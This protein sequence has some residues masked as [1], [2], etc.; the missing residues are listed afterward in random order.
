MSK[1]SFNPDVDVVEWSGTQRPYDIIK[2]G[3]IALVVMSLLVVLLSVLFSSPDDRPA[4]LRQWSHSDPVDFATTAFSEL[5][6]SSGTAGYGQPY[7]NTPNATQTIGPLALQRWMGVRIPVHPAADFVLAPLAT[8]PDNPAIVAALQQWKLSS[9]SE[10]TMWM[11]NYGKVTPSFSNG[12][13]HLPDVNAGPIPVLMSS[14]TAMARAGSLDQSLLGGGRNYY[15][16]DYTRP[17]L[18]LADGNWFSGLAEKQHL[19][20]DQWGMMNETG[21]Y[22]G[23]AWLWLYTFWYQVPPFNASANADSLIWGLMM[24]LTVIMIFV[25]FIPGV[26]SIPRRTKVYRLIWRNH[27]RK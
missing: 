15:S 5:N 14:L 10:R 6:G 26:R 20:G 21:S 3:T 25:P 24:V 18:F 16:T 2:E 17:L 7:N 27:Y 19:A 4:T 9:E 22:P 12:A 23:Q 8:L 11:D 13:L 1:K